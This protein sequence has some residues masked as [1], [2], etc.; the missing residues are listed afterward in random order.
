MP[1]LCRLGL[2][3]ASM[4]VGVYEMVVLIVGADDTHL[5]GVLGAIT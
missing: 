1:G 5:S 2:G 4:A 3:Q